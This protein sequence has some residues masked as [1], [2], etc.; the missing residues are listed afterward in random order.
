MEFFE[1]A[2]IAEAL[3]YNDPYKHYLWAYLLI[4]ALGFGILYTFQ[5]FALYTIATRCGTERR[6]MSFVPLL[7]TYY[8]GV[9]ADKN[10]IFNKVKP[11]Y[12]SLAMAVLE[13]I[14]IVL[15]ILYY[16]ASFN[17]FVG[18][19]AEP[20]YETVVSL[21]STWQILNGYESVNLPA[22]LLW[23]W[24]MAMSMP[25]ALMY[26][27]E[28]AYR[29]L[30]VFVL[31]SFFRTYSSPRYVIFVIFSVLFPIKGIFMFAVRNNK[32]KNYGEYLREQQMRQY[33]MYQQYMRDGQN[34]GNYYNNNG[35]GGQYGNGANSG[36]GGQY[37]QGNPYGQGGQRPTPEDPFDG[38]G[39]QDKTG[40]AGGNGSH[41]GDDPFSDL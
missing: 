3:F 35:Y 12:F 6:W 39:G 22:N 20:V 28:L 33:R 30:G 14:Y 41:G 24:W 21:G 13:G 16:M 18:G 25:S 17:I 7:N 26:W 1:I 29:L 37:N 27:V 8:I 11:K 23:L 34:G 19:F 2:N 15:G 10:R 9:L 4:G 32:D 36:Y 31:V 40:G 5:A 38:L